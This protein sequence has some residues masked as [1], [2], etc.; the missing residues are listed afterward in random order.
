[1]NLFFL[2]LIQ[3]EKKRTKNRTSIFYR[4]KSWKPQNEPPRGIEPGD[5]VFYLQIHIILLDGNSHLWYKGPHVPSLFQVSDTNFSPFYWEEIK[6]PFCFNNSIIN[7]ILFSF[8]K[9]QVDGFVKIKIGKSRYKFWV[10]KENKKTLID[11]L[12]RK[13]ASSF[14][15][16][17]YGY[18]STY[19][20]YVG[21]GFDYP[22]DAD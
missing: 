3:D 12:S 20:Y 4:D 19:G 8:R 2:S 16:F 11:K 1:M 21:I 9:S 14:P 13:N 7:R 18:H 15:M 17:S 6:V 22:V 5:V 10:D